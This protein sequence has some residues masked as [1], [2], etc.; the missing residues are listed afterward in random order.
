ME[1][2]VKAKPEDIREHYQSQLKAMQEACGEACSS[3]GPGKKSDAL[4]GKKNVT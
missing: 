2:A 3:Y 1:N 4:P